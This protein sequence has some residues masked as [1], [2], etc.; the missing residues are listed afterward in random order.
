MRYKIFSK[1]LLSYAAD[2]LFVILL[3]TAVILEVM[4]FKF[5]IS[6]EAYKT[7]PMESY[8]VTI[9]LIPCAVTV[10]SVV[11]G[12]YKDKI[13]G[14]TISD[15]NEIR[16]K[17]YFDHLHKMV[18]VC[19]LLGAHS[20]LFVHTLKIS[21]YCLEAISFLYSIIF[22]FQ[23]ISIVAHPKSAV[24]RV[25]KQKYLLKEKEESPF[26]DHG[27]NTFETI[28]LNILMAEGIK[29]AFKTLRRH[30]ANPYD[31]ID[32]LMAKQDSYFHNVQENVT[33]YQLNQTF[34]LSDITVAEAV[35]CGYENIRIVIS[36][37]LSKKLNSTELQKHYYA[38]AMSLLQLHDL[39]CAL[40]LGEKEK[41]KVNALVSYDGI[42]HASDF[43]NA[44]GLSVVVYML[45][46]TLNKGDPWFLK[47]LRDNDWHPRELFQFGEQPIGFFACM[48]MNHLSTKSI[49]ADSEKQAIE[50]VLDE[51]SKG[52]NADGTKWRHWM[53]EAPKRTKEENIPKSISTFLKYYNSVS[54]S[55]FDFDGNR[56]TNVHDGNDTFKKED[57]FHDWLLL[58]FASAR[59]YSPTIDLSKILADLAP[60]DKEALAEEL[61][62]NWLEEGKL[63]EVIDQSFLDF[64]GLRRLEFKVV[65]H[66]FKGVVEQLVNFHDDF[67][68]AKERKPQCDDVDL[69]PDNCLIAEEFEKALKANP[70]YDPT[71]DVSNGTS[72]SLFKMIW[73]Y[74]HKSGLMSFLRQIPSQLDRRIDEAV[75]ATAF[76][77]EKSDKTAPDDIAKWILDLKPEFESTAYWAQA[78]LDNENNRYREEIG[79]LNLKKVPNLTSEVYWRE[80][81]IR[82]NAKIDE[83]ASLIR[84]LGNDEIESIIQRYYKPF[85]NG[86][87]RY[88]DIGDNDKHSFYITKEE[89]IKRLKST[90]YYI[91]LSFQYVVSV[92]KDKTLLIE[93]KFDRS[94]F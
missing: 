16:G 35:N 62:E 25:V 39:C 1:H 23:D 64:L 33:K 38:L 53:Q 12:I 71:I 92:D 66:L 13:Y 7:M 85:E 29:E 76:K 48:L 42:Y 14:A 82:F 31:L 94:G 55:V 34:L 52:L 68:R 40:E 54:E 18:V 69:T 17:W 28:V 3:I 73:S 49:W 86:L 84:R 90:N 41:E 67:Y 74:N 61:S 27:D 46:N 30:D 59:V 8:A 50:A 80:G 19:V 58:V 60:N 72:D 93:H 6:E 56:I 89:L 78:Y 2:A 32:Y 65:N 75:G 63:K 36:G 22:S 57:L 77:K 10:V 44:I 9:T 47:L 15:I 11:L 79:N 70:F 87:Y 21:L 45:A 43:D 81:A 5:H 88:Y 91:F 83:K 26:R 24:K 4:G 20:L 37:E 51:K